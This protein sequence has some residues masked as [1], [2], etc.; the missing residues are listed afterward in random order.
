LTVESLYSR[1]GGR[2]EKPHA[3]GVE[4]QANLEI[5][6][7]FGN[8]GAYIWLDSELPSFQSQRRAA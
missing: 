3:L 2:R 4:P 1:W 8:P 7:L 5:A 6:E